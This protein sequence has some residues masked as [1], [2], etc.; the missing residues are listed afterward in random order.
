MTYFQVD[1]L[2]WIRRLGDDPEF[3][4]GHHVLSDFSLDVS[5]LPF[6][7]VASSD[8][9]DKFAHV[10]AHVSVQLSTKESVI[11]CGFGLQ[12]RRNTWSSESPKKV[13]SRLVMCAMTYHLILPRHIQPLG[14]QYPTSGCG[15]LTSLNWTMPVSPNMETEEYAASGWMKSW[16]RAIS[17]E[18][19][20]APMVTPVQPSKQSSYSWLSY[21]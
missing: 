2:S 1:D 7:F 18:R 13:Y 19:K 10:R 15:I 17:S 6:E 8:L 11:F 9:A 4:D 20:S 21:E 5:K 14:P 3:G 12:Q 16:Q